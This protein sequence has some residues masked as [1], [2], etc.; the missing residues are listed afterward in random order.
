[1]GDAVFILQYLYWQKQTS[2]RADLPS[3]FSFFY[4]LA[5]TSRVIFVIFFLKLKVER[6]KKTKHLLRK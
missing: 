1:M 5:K 3:C 2:K 4:V 6:F